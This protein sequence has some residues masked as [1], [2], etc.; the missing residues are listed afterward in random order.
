MRTEW[1]LERKSVLDALMGRVVTD[2]WVHEMALYGEA[3]EAH[4]TDPNLDFVQASV[5][6]LR[7]SD[8]QTLQI[9]CWQTDDTFALWPR[10]VASHHQLIPNP[11]TGIFRIRPMPE[12]PL[13]PVS[14]VQIGADNKLGIQEVCLTINQQRVFL[15]AGK[16]YEYPE[17]MLRVND[18]DES[19]L[20]FLNGEAYSRLMFNEL[21]FKRFY[22]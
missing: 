10:F 18:R 14:N 17:G 2:A 16:V 19:V 3:D 6:E 15:R 22:P 21:I 1:D 11:G 9:S 5:L 8:H 4:F 20:V 13:G 7:T 12:F